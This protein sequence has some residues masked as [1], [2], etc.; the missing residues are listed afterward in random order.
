[1][2]REQ[3]PILSKEQ[4]MKSSRWTRQLLK[5]KG[6]GNNDAEIDKEVWEITKGEVQS[7][8]LK[9]PFSHE[10][11]VSKLGPLYVV[12]DR[13]GIRQGSEVRQIDDL[14]ANLVNPA[15]AAAEKL[16]LGG[17]DEI[18]ALAKLM[19]DSIADDGTVVM[20]L[21]DGSTLRGK[22]SSDL[23]ARLVTWWAV[24]WIFKRP[25]SRY[26][27]LW[28]PCGQQWFK[29]ATQMSKEMSCV[30]LMCYPSVRRPRFL[31]S[32]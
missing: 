11:L 21:S 27:C 17:I 14:S 10:E 31:L 13:F 29:F 25:T 7:G 28:S 26:W 12:C 8:W 20:Q 22:L 19:L 18:A 5:A 3:E 1:M 2:P 30:S 24:L 9:G 15:F 32:T 16:D 4:V 23:T 6:A